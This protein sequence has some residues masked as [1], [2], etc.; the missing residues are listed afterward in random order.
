[1]S[2]QNTSSNSQ[3][4]FSVLRNLEIVLEGYQGLEELAKLS[5]GDLGSGLPIS[6]VMVPL[7]FQF[8]DILV[9]LKKMADKSRPADHRGFSV[10]SMKKEPSDSEG[11][12]S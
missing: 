12:D 8:E 11:Q 3:N 7:N 1:M 4:L 6:N 2:G 10:V 9:S 5:A